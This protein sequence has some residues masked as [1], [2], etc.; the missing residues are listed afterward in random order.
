MQKYT[1]RQE[2]D[3]EWHAVFRKKHSLLFSGLAFLKEINY[4]MKSSSPA[5]KK[6]ISK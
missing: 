5:V 2:K 4:Y 6:Y 3:H 1:K